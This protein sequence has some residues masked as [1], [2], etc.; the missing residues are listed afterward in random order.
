[1]RQ[2]IYSNK[3]FIELRERLNAEI[4]R[5]AGFKWLDPLAT[6]TVGEDKSSP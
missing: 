2:D 1:M 4:K 6:P 5:R 3:E